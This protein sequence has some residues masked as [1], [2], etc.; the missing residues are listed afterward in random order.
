MKIKIALLAI[1]LGGQGIG[2]SQSVAAINVA[3]VSDINQITPFHEGLAAV[4]K[5]DA[6]GFIDSQG[7]LVID[8]RNDLFGN[9]SVNTKTSDIATMPYPRF[10]NGRCPIRVYTPEEPGIPLYGFI[11]TTGKTV[12]PPNFLNASEFKD[13]I[14]VAIYFKKNFRGKNAFQL[15]IYDYAFTEVVLNPEGEMIWPLTE[16]THISMDRKRY[17]TPKLLGQILNR[18]LIGMGSEAYPNYLEI[19]KLNP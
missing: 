3:T 6:W 5:G 18:N 7:A 10:H 19:R 14:A 12:I 4:R 16:R 8:F 11:D 15:Q 2:W 13:G 9:P 17:K 1:L